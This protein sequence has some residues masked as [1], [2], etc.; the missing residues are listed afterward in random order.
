[1]KEMIA[2]RPDN[3]WEEFCSIGADVC[4]GILFDKHGKM[5]VARQRGLKLDKE[6]NLY[7]VSG[8]KVCRYTADLEKSEYLRS[9]DYQSFFSIA[10]SPDMNH[11]YLTDF[12]TKALVRYDIHKVCRM[13]FSREA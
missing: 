3:A 9:R 10:F 12:F 2:M 4:G 13:R 11:L 8:G 5:L 1:M 7:V 6:G